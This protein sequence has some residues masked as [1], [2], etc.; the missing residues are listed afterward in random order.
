MKCSGI[1]E[2]SIGLDTDL[3]M[4]RSRGGWQVWRY[5]YQLETK[6][7]PSNDGR[8]R[9]DIKTVKKKAVIDSGLT[10]GEAK[11][12]LGLVHFVESELRKAIF[13]KIVNYKPWEV[14]VASNNGGVTDTV[15]DV[16]SKCGSVSKVQ[17]ED[18]QD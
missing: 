4:R 1:L 5:V 10:R 9:Y 6:V 8:L 16:L 12:V 18:I 13:D 15:S 3:K 2:R 17:P 7:Q 14:S 11:N